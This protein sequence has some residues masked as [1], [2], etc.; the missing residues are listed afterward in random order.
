M[1]ECVGATP[2]IEAS[3]KAVAAGGRVVLLGSPRTKMEMDP[4]WDIHRRGVQ[5]IGAH[6]NAV[7][8]ATRQRDRP[9]L[10]D[11]LASGRLAVRELITQH[12]AL[13][14][15]QTAYEGLAKLPDEF[16]GVVFTYG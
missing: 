14:E 1:V 4:Y 11:L 2:T 3:L 5:V 6:G 16:V 7:D 15:A 9:F 8:A 10:V 13:S 12:F